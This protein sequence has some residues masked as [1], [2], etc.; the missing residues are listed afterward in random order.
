LL[1]TQSQKDLYAA[2]KHVALAAA[3]G[4]E[5]QTADYSEAGLRLGHVVEREVI[6]PCFD[7]LHSFLHS[8][9]HA[10]LAGL[11]LGK[12][13]QYRVAM[14]VPLWADAWTTMPAAALKASQRPQD[15]QLYVET[16]AEPPLSASDR[17]LLAAF[18]AQW[19]H[20]MSA[21]FQ[22]HGDA[23]ATYLDQISQVHQL[24]TQA[25]TPLYQWAF[26]HM[27][28]LVIGNAETPGLLQRIYA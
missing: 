8:Q 7:D 21:W 6:R 24:A 25:S 9:G 11:P 3:D 26:E 12:P 15:S 10:T 20:P 14:A 4:S 18:L 27:R 28:D 22:A 1:Q 19:E 16:Q 5:P 17:A 2:Y 23:A 13:H